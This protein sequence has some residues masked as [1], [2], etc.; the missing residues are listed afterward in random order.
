[1]GTGKSSTTPKV[2]YLDRCG[3]TPSGGPPVKIPPWVD[4]SAATWDAKTKVAVEGNVAHTATFKA[5]H[6]GSNEVIT[7]NG[8]PARSGTFPVA[9]SDPAYAYNPNPGSITAHSIKVTVPYNPKTNSS[10]RCESGTVGIAANGI[11]ILDG[12]DAGGNDAGGVEV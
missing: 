12:F 5:T 10:P 1:L 6:T 2:G 3:G 9:Q 4:T 11:P 7:G 8:L